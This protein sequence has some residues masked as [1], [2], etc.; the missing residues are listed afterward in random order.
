[1]PSNVA[2]PEIERL[3]QLLARLP[4]LGPRSARRAAL[5]LIRKRETLLQPLAEAMRVA[6]ERIVICSV[7]GNVDTRDPCTICAD[8]RPRRRRPSWWSNRSA[9]S[10]RS[11][12]PARSRARYHVLGGV[13][14]PLD[15]VGPDDLNIAAARRARRARAGSSEVI[16]AVNATVD[17]QTTA[18]YLIDLPRRL[19]GQGHAARPWRAGRRRTRLSR[20]RH[21]RRGHAP[22]DSVLGQDDFWTNR[23]RPTVRPLTRA[24]PGSSPT[25][26]TQV[27]LVARRPSP[28]SGEGGPEG[29]MGCGKQGIGR[30]NS[31]R[32]WCNPTQSAAADHTPSGASRHLPRQS[33]RRIAARASRSVMLEGSRPGAG[34]SRAGEGN[35]GRAL[36]P[37][38][39]RSR[40]SF[41]PA[42]SFPDPLRNR[43]IIPCSGRLKFPV[44]RPR[45]ARNRRVAKPGNAMTLQDFLERSADRGAKKFP[46]SREPDCRRR[47]ESATILGRTRFPS[48]QQ[49]RFCKADCHGNSAAAVEGHKWFLYPCRTRARRLHKTRGRWRR[50][51]SMATAAASRLFV[52]PYPRR[53][54]KPLGTLSTILALRRNPIEIWSQAHFDRPILVGRSILGLRAAAHDPAAVRRVFLDNAA[55]YRKD[56]LQ[57]RFRARASAPDW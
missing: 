49:V 34:F 28:R 54:T 13:L 33:W 7:C 53:A 50:R 10:G 1:M 15:G 27:D 51:V 16:L 57:L 3:I 22:A 38:R 39:A 5:H 32:R 35:A 44:P 48:A 45:A 12:A 6:E 17:G 20:R 56:A 11:S 55:N 18:H 4:G 30:L 19:S 46:A 25:Q 8:P 24:A 37:G 23:R 47:T 40:A 2:G 26:F 43:L 21:D 42:C 52:P 36:Q 14:S 41:S 29:R 31:G 9:I